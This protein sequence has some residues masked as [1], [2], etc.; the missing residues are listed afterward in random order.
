MLHSC[1]AVCYLMFRKYSQ[2]PNTVV[3]RVFLV[4]F[5][6]LIWLGF[7]WISLQI[8]IEN[9]I[10]NLI[11]EKHHILFNRTSFFQV[12]VVESFY[13]E[14]KIIILKI[15]VI[16]IYYIIINTVTVCQIKMQHQYTQSI[17]RPLRLSAP[18]EC[19][20]RNKRPS[21]NKRP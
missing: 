15:N 12:D 16:N 3:F 7:S 1:S 11:F 2:Y 20:F 8:Y 18:I 9:V 14:Q 5:E 19:E 21:S 6:F 10:A 17:Q 4:Y 13:N